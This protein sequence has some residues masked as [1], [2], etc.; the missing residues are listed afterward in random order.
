MDCIFC[1]IANGEINSSKYYEDDIVM[2]F[3]DITPDCDG[4]TL[5]IPKKHYKDLTDI[6][7]DTLT[8]I[9]EVAKK[10]KLELENKLGCGGLSL[11]QNN[12]FCQEVKHFHLHLKPFYKG[13]KTIELVKHKENIH[14]V[15][16][17]YEILKK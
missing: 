3:L 6:D 4:H 7:M 14:D 12:G 10:L 5:I 15:S 2:A 9:M 16:E 13:V 17:I 11:L 1:K 8:H